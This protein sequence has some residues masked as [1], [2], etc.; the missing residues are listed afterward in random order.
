MEQTFYTG[1][2]LIVNLIPV[3]MAKLQ[4]K[5]YTP[6]REQ[7]IVF[8]NPNYVTGNDDMYLVKRVIAF[9]GERVVVRDGSITVYNDEHPEGFNPDKDVKGPGAPTSGDIDTVVPEGSIF[10]SGDHRDGQH[11]LDSRNGLGTV[12]LFDVI[13]PVKIRIWPITGI[14]FY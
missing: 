10:V 13:G 6:E 14:G 9:G 5:T 11:S 2:R 7:V 8:K 4:N 12:P 1:D 3:T